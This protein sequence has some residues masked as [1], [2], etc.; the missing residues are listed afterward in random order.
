MTNVIEFNAAPTDEHAPVFK[1]WPK[2]PRLNKPIYISEKI[3]GTNGAIIVT[4]D[5]RVA[6]QSRNRLITPGKATDNYGFAQWVHENAG[7]LRDTLGVGHHYGEWAGKGIQRGYDLEERA[8]FLFNPHWAEEVKRVDR[9]EVAPQLLITG[10]FDSFDIAQTLAA[11]VASGSRVDGKTNPEGIIIYHSA[12]RQVYKLL[13]EGDQP[14]GMAGRRDHDLLP[15][16]VEVA[17]LVAA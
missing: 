6:A 3:D 8:F 2:T 14:K 13:A 7:V 10:E 12:S 16:P 15:A 17:S 9:L 11:L 1:P 5:G 4:R